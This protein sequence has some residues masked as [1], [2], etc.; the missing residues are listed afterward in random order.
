M[1]MTK[2]HYEAIAEVIREELDDA[3]EMLGT[4][5][6][7]ADYEAVTFQDGRAFALR[8]TAK[9]FATLFATDNASFDTGRFLSACGIEGPTS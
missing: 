3:I 4:Y 9:R 2:R 7:E 8:I 6:L 5:K 1:A